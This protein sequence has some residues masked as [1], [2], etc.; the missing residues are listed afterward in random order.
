[1]NDPLDA[2]YKYIDAMP[3]GGM[4]SVMLHAFV[5]ALLLN[6]GAALIVH[7]PPKSPPDEIVMISSPLRIEHRHA[8]FSV[9][10]RRPKEG[11][12][13]QRDPSS[14]E[15]SADRAPE[16]VAEVPPPDAVAHAQLSIDEGRREKLH[17]GEG[18]YRPIQSWTSE[19]ERYYRVEYEFV[20]PDGT[21]ESGVVPWVVHFAPGEDP[22]IDG[23]AEAR[24]RTQLPPPPPGFVPPGT[25]GRA[26]RAYFPNLQFEDG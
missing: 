2:R 11:N 15:T 12:R 3:L 23:T 1:M 22:F 5:G 19:G 4:T 17:R 24:P 26:L 20:Y 9:R 13:P 10:L 14:D 7:V 8:A 18:T 21:K 6:F 16:Q 25:L